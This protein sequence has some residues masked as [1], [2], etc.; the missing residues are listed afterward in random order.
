MLMETLYVI[1]SFLLS[2]GACGGVIFLSRK[3]NV[4]LSAS[5]WKELTDNASEYDA[6]IADIPQ[7]TEGIASKSQ[8]KTIA[9]QTENFLAG[10]ESQRALLKELEAR[11]ENANSQVI[12]KER[13][14]QELKSFKEEEEVKLLEVTSNYQAIADKSV[15][16]EQELAESLR[17]LDLIGN[18]VPMTDDQKATF[19]ALSEALSDA[20]TVL[21]DLIMD[22]QT[23]Q[24]R[25]NTLM[26]QR[27][28][29]ENEYTKLVEQQ[30]GA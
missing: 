28:E 19:T 27:D 12:E 5:A 11:L 7:E 18:D 30:L 2:I 6:V 3:K 20:G 1:L 13:S 14:Q 4:T 21:R 16:L 10:L 15:A 24:E 22:N 26:A 17:N 9:T 29:L 23:A 25:L 8:L